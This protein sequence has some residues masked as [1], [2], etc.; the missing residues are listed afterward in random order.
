[1]TSV[2]T[3]SVRRRLVG[4]ALTVAIVGVG[5]SA[6]QMP[7]APTIQSFTV[8]NGAPSLS[9]SVMLRW[10]MNQ[11]AAPNQPAPWFRTR[12]RSPLESAWPMWGKYVPN[13]RGA[14]E[15]AA[16]L[17]RRSAADPLPGQHWFELQVKDANGQE[18]QVATSSV[19]RALP[20]PPPPPP[21]PTAFYEVSGSAASDV[22]RYARDNGFG[23]EAIAM[24][25]RSTCVLTEVENVFRF[26]SARKPVPA[27]LGPAQCHFRLFAKRQLNAGWHLRQLTLSLVVTPSEPGYSFKLLTQP[28]PFGTDASVVAEGVISWP[29]GGKLPELIYLDGRVTEVELDG[30]PGLTWQD[31]FKD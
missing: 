23:F 12:Y 29:L 17:A 22:I 6:R 25:E 11:P 24:N 31:A 14:Y 7:A 30:P 9:D 1:M 20:S 18:S 5:A 4:A 16:T 8:N 13:T 27:L 28:K 15:V 3:S 2:F 21:A 19:I 26:R 10:T